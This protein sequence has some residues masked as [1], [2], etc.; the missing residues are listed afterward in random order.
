VT[1]LRV[2]GYDTVYAHDE[3]DSALLRRA[4]L[5]QRI[6]ITRDRALAQAQSARTLLVEARAPMEQLAEVAR[7][8]GLRLDQRRMFTRCSLCNGPVQPVDK[9]QVRDRLPD[10]AGALYDQLTY[11]PACD[12]VYWKGNQYERMMAF[13][14]PLLPGTAP[15]AA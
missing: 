3:A 13:L 2:L 1:W 12:K 4:R 10:A 14:A 15:D 5:E 7:A 8:L 11:C 6:L 9:E